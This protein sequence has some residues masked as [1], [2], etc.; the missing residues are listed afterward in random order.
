MNM[1]APPNVGVGTLCTRRS[2]GPTTAPT[3]MAKRR[4]KGVVMNVTAAATAKMMP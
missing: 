3:R 2:S 1:A 4:T